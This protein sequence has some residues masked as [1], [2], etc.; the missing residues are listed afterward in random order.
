MVDGP[1]IFSLNIRR[2]VTPPPPSRTKNK[3]ERN[4][5]IF[6]NALFLVLWMTSQAL[7]A[8]PITV[9]ELYT[10]QGCSSCP[11]ADAALHALASDPD[12][13]SEV[14]PL[15]F[16]VDY[17]DYIG[18]VDPFSD[19][20]WSNRQ[21]RYAQSLRER[22][23]YTPQLIVNGRA[24]RVSPPTVSGLKRLITQAQ[25]PTPGD[26]S[27]EVVE[28]GQSLKGTASLK[29]KNP[30]RGTA[31]RLTFVLYQ[32]APAT[33]VRRGVI[34]GRKLV[35]GWVVRDLWKGP[36]APTQSGSS[37]KISHTF[38]RNPAWGNQGW[39]IAVLL[40]DDNTRHILHA[41]RSKKS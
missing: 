40:Q 25:Q 22:Q 23:I 39:G 8:P 29:L 41:A 9:L 12:L 21:R 24:H 17:W 18:W 10:S 15:A 35:N 5:V 26:L 7:A 4:V 11:R 38:E 1:S 28:S 13:A 16:H 32:Q 20:R 27:V 3:R 2:P 33:Q 19:P 34:S 6:R 36:P 30:L 37:Q 14:I 31:P